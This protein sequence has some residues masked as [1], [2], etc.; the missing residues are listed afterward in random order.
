MIRTS[1]VETVASERRSRA[2]RALIAASSIEGIEKIPRPATAI[3]IVRIVENERAR[4][5]VKSDHDLRNSVE[6][7]MSI[8][9]PHVRRE[10]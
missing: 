5:R 2:T 10:S 7:I 3:A 9:R 4:W 8:L 1:T 6:A